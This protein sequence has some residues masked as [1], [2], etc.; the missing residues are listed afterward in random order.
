SGWL[1]ATCRETHARAAKLA[2]GTVYEFKIPLWATS[3]RVARGHRIRLVIA[4]A[5]FPRIWP[6]KN[7]P[8]IQ[9][10]FGGNRA[11]AVSIPIVERGG[12]PDGPHV[13]SIPP[14]ALPNPRVPIW[15]IERDMVS[16]T[17]TV[18]TGQKVAV[19]LP[20]GGVLQVDHAASARVSAN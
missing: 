2:H 18:T 20:Q 16:G 5:D 7:N 8:E 13:R 4:C 15:K 11:S 1:R 17:V 6:T 10:F 19:P 12:A 3:Y 14:A 9:I